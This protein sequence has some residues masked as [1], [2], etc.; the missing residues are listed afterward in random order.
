MAIAAALMGAGTTAVALLGLH[1]LRHI[2]TR[3]VVAH[4]AGVASLVAV[5]GIG[6]FPGVTSGTRWDAITFGL[7]LGVAACGTAGQLCLTRAYALGRPAS[8]AIVGLTQIAFAVLFD[9][10]FWGRTLTP[11]V[12][13]GFA[14]VALPSAALGATAGGRLRGKGS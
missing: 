10:A 13:A 1:R 8:L 6:L 12:A 7:L 2:D 14:L 9:V 5:A 3:A 11:V 4:F